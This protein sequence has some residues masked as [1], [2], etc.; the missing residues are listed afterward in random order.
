VSALAAR[1]GMALGLLIAGAEY[2]LAH[3]VSA[4]TERLPVIGPA[5]DFTLTSQ[6]NRPVA[7]ADLRG[8]VVALTFI[9]TS[10]TDTC[11]VLTALMAKV[12][13]DLGAAFGSKVAFVSITVDPERDT[14]AALKKYAE[15]FGADLRGWS[16]LTGSPE[17]ISD[18]EHRY[19]VIAKKADDG[20]IDHTLLT[21]LID[22]S[23]TMR[24]QYLGYSFD[25]REFRSDLISLE[26]K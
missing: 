9:Y 12:Q 13:Q 6:D 23:G 5:P 21:S 20:D 2:G 25:P 24:V 26:D 22:T 1:I 10:C 15:D 8:K 7:L 16:F 18:V 11:P 14:P 17:A 19:G 4:H 3:E